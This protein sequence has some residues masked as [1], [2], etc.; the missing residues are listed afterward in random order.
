MIYRRGSAP[1]LKMKIKGV[2]QSESVKACSRLN[3]GGSIYSLPISSLIS[4]CT[5][6]VNLSGLTI[7]KMINRLNFDASF[8]LPGHF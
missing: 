3:G 1:G 7:L 5:D 8:H 4:F 6:C 2:L